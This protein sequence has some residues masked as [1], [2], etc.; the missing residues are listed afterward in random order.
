MA[1]AVTRIIERIEQHRSAVVED[2][3]AGR[4]TIPTREATSSATAPVR[5]HTEPAS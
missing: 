4:V 1:P 2:L 5:V 3:G